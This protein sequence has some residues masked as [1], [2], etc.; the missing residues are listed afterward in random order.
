MLHR[1]ESETWKFGFIKW[2][3][4]GLFNTAKDLKTWRF[5]RLLVALR[6]GESNYV[7]PMLKMSA[8]QIF[9]SGYSVFINSFDKTK[10]FMESVLLSLK[11][12]VY[13]LPIA[14][15]TFP[16]CFLFFMLS[17]NKILSLNCYFL[18]SKKIMI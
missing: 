17:F 1:R 3:D 11:A 13:S 10:F 5:E 2:V 4:K 7:G 6:Q 18:I 8:F 15:H 16:W 14:V 9:R 12:L